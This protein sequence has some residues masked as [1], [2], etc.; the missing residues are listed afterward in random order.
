MA[1]PIPFQHRLVCS[2]REVTDRKQQRIIG[3]TK[4]YEM[5]ADG[6]I[7]T[8]KVDGRRLIVVASLLELLGVRENDAA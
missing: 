4:L 5:I 7:E 2:V 6:R 8:K 1:H 3:R